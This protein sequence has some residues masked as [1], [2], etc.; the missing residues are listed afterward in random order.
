M[1]SKTQF[2]DQHVGALLSGFVDGELT[3]QDRQRVSLHC[4][5]CDECRESLARLRELRERIGNARLSEIGED[6]WRETMNDSS[7]ETTRGLG[8]ILFIAGIVIAAGI[9]LF[10]FLFVSDVPIGVKLLMIVIYGGLALLLVSVLRQRMIE[11]KTDKYK[12]V[13]I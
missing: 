7:V 3:Q 1:S 12:D 13:E 8:W 10:T 5:Q 9:G 6:R 2:V 4:E 11:H